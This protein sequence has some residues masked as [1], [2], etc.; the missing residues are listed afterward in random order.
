MFGNDILHHNISP[1]DGSRTHEC[2][3]FNLIGNNGI[4]GSVKFC[5]PFD[6]YGIRTGTLYIGT[7]T[8]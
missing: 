3:S 7:H 5:Y 8:V 1:C 4:F 2:T 6:T